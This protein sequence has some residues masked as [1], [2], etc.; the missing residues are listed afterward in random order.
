MCKGYKIYEVL[1]LRS[2]TAEENLGNRA[3]LWQ[4]GVLPKTLRISLASV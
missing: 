2:L 3:P 4:V 1:A